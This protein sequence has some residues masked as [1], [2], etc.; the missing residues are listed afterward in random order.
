MKRECRGK[1]EGKVGAKQTLTGSN[2]A[3]ERESKG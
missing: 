2:K 1:G 3:E